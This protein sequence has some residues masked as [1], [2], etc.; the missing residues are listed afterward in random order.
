LNPRSA[1]LFFQYSQT[2]AR[3]EN[4]DNP[5]SDFW[6]C[7]F[8]LEVEHMVTLRETEKL[9]LWN[10]LY[11]DHLFTTYGFTLT[12]KEWETFR[13]WT[14]DSK[15][16]T[17]VDDLNIEMLSNS[18]PGL[19]RLYHLVLPKD[20]Y[21]ENFGDAYE[22]DWDKITDEAKDFKEQTATCQEAFTCPEQASFIGEVLVT[23]VFITSG[24]IK[25]HFI[26]DCPGLQ[27][28]LNPLTSVTL[29][30]AKSLRRTL[31]AY[32]QDMTRFR[33]L[34]CSTPTCNFKTTWMPHFCCRRCKEGRGHGKLCT[35]YI[36]ATSSSTPMEGISE[37]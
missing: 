2:L 9:G 6:L 24:G 36:E 26:E 31:C 16:G 13:C 21:D 37:E 10:R 19:R 33:T 20:F 34:E 30:E 17:F 5:N 8:K 12:D 29:Q 7:S 35:G 4:L 25:F 18:S 23:E 15:V 28:R 14:F 32:C 11:V 3:S 1:A 22:E 27:K